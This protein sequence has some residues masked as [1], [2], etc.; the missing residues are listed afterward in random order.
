[1]SYELES[2]VMRHKD[3]LQEIQGKLDKIERERDMNR[4]LYETECKDLA[5]MLKTLERVIRERDRYRATLEDI[6][7]GHI[8]RGAVQEKIEEAL[9]YNAE[10]VQAQTRTPND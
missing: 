6:Y 1:M 2:M 7:T 5:F 9:N 4:R 3:Q 10:N 8:L